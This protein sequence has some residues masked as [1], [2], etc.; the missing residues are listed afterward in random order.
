VNLPVTNTSDT[1]PVTINQP[2]NDV[3]LDGRFFGVLGLMQ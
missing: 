3:F 1:F 2:N